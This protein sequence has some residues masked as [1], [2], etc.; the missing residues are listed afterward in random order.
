MTKDEF[1]EAFGEIEVTFSHYYK[2]TFSYTADL[3]DGS[4]LS[5]SL[6]GNADDIYREEVSNN[7]KS[8]V[9]ALSPYTG[10]VYKDEVEVCSFYDY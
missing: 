5:V 2:Y 8:S 10:S 6:G 3:P 1:I 4:K 7:H 9:S